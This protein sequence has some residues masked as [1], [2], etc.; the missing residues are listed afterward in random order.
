MNRY[1]I[2]GDYADGYCED[3][4]PVGNPPLFGAAGTSFAPAR[5]PGFPTYVLSWGQATQRSAGLQSFGY[6]PYL[7]ELLIRLSWSGMSAADRGAL[8]TFHAAVNG[9]ATPFSLFS[10]VAGP[11]MQVRFSE[12]TLPEMPEVAFGRH[13][14]DLTLRV[15]NSFPTPPSIGAPQA[16]TGNRFVCLGAAFPF[17]AP[18]RPTSGFSLRRPQSMERT[19]NGAAVIYNSSRLQLL[20]HR[21]TV[22]LDF[23]GFIRLQA[24]FFSFTHGSRY[25]FQ[26]IDEAGAS[27]NLR[28][29]DTSIIVRQIMSN[30]YETEL[31][32][33]EEL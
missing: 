7:Q 27:R 28:L 11:T 10:P 17:P 8:I 21:Y 6:A 18:L 33:V 3:W 24:L 1:S 20:Q 13:R 4:A 15:A 29:N 23:D 16:I 12:D 9:M 25:P 30:R 19:S 2:Y 22:A 32:L 26:W 14:V 5:M 31:P